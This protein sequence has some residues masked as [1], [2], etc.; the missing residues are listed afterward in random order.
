M[1]FKMIGKP[2]FITVDGR[3]YEYQIMKWKD[4]RKSIRY[5]GIVTYSENQKIKEILSKKYKWLKEMINNA[6]ISK[7]YVHNSKR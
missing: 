7:E 2:H 1:D 5:N 6:K 4:G 3:T